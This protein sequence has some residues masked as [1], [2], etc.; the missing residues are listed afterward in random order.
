MARTARAD[1]FTVVE[2]V[3]ASALLVIGVLAAALLLDVANTET[4][5]AKARTA[6]NNVA[7]RVVEVARTVSLSAVDQA[8]GPALVQSRAPDL[9]DEDPAPGWT[10][11]RGGVTYTI[12]WSSCLLDDP[13]DG[14]AADAARTAAYC[15]QPA[16][17]TPPDTTPADARRITVTVS[18]TLREDRRVRAVAVLP[19]GVGD[20]PVVQRVLLEGP[21]LCAGACTITSDSARFRAEVNTS[22]SS[23]T[24]L[25]E[26]AVAA[27]CPPAGACTG[28]GRTWNYDWPI[29]T[30]VRETA[31]GVNAGRCK[32]GAYRPDGTYEVG[33]RAADPFGRART[34]VSQSVLLNRCTPWPVAALA[35]GHSFTGG[36][37]DIEWSPPADGDIIGYRVY[38]GASMA[39]MVPACGLGAGDW[40][41]VSDRACTDAQ[42]LPGTSYFYFVAAVDRSPQGAVRV[43]YVSGVVVARANHPPGRV[44]G[45]DA[46]RA[47]TD[48]TLTWTAS[49]DSDAG[50]QVTAYR[51]YR[52]PSG[53]TPGIAD[54]VGRVSAL[55]A[56][57]NAVSCRWTDSGAP[58]G[59]AYHVTAVDT[60][61]AES[62]MSQGDPA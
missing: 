8:S 55:D 10:V 58:A 18:W 49:S 45:L 38:K 13:S 16:P 4:A 17:S 61:A 28:A 1:G 39:T 41:P 34:P 59:V 20:L 15:G 53:A 26:G 6:G 9:A 56:C 57:P 2:V 54:R 30:P 11:R 37:T 19:L 51:I 46:T 27:S 52:V 43:G 7:R 42:A 29:G 47:G 14:T 5:G 31:A 50:D 23:V 48:V 36:V 22:A 35:A 21:P 32:P 62:A 60:R 12:G 25:V 24:W 40:L 3:V 33:A 44:T